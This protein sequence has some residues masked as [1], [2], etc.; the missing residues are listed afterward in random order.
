MLIN[1]N[2]RVHNM[3]TSNYIAL[4]CMVSIIY[5]TDIGLR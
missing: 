4:I 1:S 5:P 2:R 3:I